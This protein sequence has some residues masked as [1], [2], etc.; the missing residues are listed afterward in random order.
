MD[1]AV[2]TYTLEPCGGRTEERK[3]A[4]RTE[5]A[6]SPRN[7]LN[8]WLDRNSRLREV[9]EYPVWTGETF[10]A[11]KHES[12]CFQHITVGFKA[13]DHCWFSLLLYSAV[14]RTLLCVT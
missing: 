14:H 7:K 2:G 12:P 13:W 4:P 8:L 9:T 5:L 6:S 1:V 11:A 3:M 10:D